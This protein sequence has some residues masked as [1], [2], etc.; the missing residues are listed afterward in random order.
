[1][2]FR[3][4]FWHLDEGVTLY[5]HKEYFEVSAKEGRLVL[6]ACAYPVQCRNDTLNN[7][8]LTTEISA[9]AENILRVDI[10]HHKGILPDKPFPEIKETYQGQIEGTTIRAKELAAE[11]KKGELTFS[12]RGR[13]LTSRFSRLSGCMTTPSGRYMAEYLTTDIGET[14]YGLGERFTPFV[15]NGQKVDM[16]NLDSGC[17]SEMSHKNIPFFISSKNYGVLLLDYGK[18]SFEMGSEVAECVQFSEKGERLSYCIIAGDCMKDIVSGYASL[19]GYPA[20]PPEWS[21]GLWLSTSFTTDYSEKTV[22]SFVDEMERRDIPLSVMHFDCFWMKEF[23]WSDFIWDPEMFPDP[24][25]LLRKLHDRGLHVSVWINPYIAQKSGL[26]DE[27][28]RKGY[29]L[30]RRDGSIWQCDVWQAGM[31]IV[32]FTY[33]EAAR[34][35]QEKLEELVRMGVDCFKTD[36]GENIPAED[37]VWHDG[38]DP[39]LMHNYYAFLYNRTVFD[40]MRKLKGDEA[41]VFGRAASIGSQQFPVHWAGD[42]VA[43]YVSM[44]ETLRG[45]LSLALSGFGF[46]SHDIGGFEDTTTPD[47][48]KRW[49]AFGL[50]SSHSR[51]HGSSSYRVPWAFDDEACK[52]T[53]FFAKLKAELLPYLWLC[54]KEAHTKGIPVIRPMIL[55]FGTGD[56]MMKYL[57]LQ[58]MLGP[59]IL[60]APVFSENGRGRCYLPEGRWISLIDGSSEEGPVWI[61]RE[62]DYFSLPLYA[63]ENSIIPI[64][65]NGRKILLAYNPGNTALEGIAE[66]H[67]REFL[68]IDDS[69]T[70]L[71]I[72]RSEEGNGSSRKSTAIGKGVQE[73]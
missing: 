73:I 41:I 63:R 5:P 12:F 32:D 17:A 65:R 4:G 27:G 20:L 47:L 64:E 72:I 46:W 59:S 36:F 7:P 10:Y 6:Y 26:F 28:A 61:D 15:K 43:S 56:E 54:A 18:A 2:R 3:N 57:D 35:Y 13:D 62:Y 31:A 16:W 19:T 40:L 70:E 38:S 67:G 29:F 11:L 60:V 48:F 50:L 22:L 68:L 21:F 55:E 71:E 25:A 45:G 58:Y 42:N 23:Q 8:V 1:M 69:Y 51:L 44:A 24:R 30:K 14:Y 66:I 33:P 9:V 39:Y 49:V 53:S 34:W 37:V 52:V